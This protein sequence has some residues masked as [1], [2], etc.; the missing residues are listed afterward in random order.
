MNH[1][2]TISILEILVILAGTAIGVAWAVWLAQSELKEVQEREANPYAP[3][4]EG[5]RVGAA[6]IFAGFTLLAGAGMLLVMFA[7]SRLPEQP[8]AARF[9]PWI[10]VAVMV[11]AVALALVDALSTHKNLDA[12]DRDPNSTPSSSF[13]PPLAEV[14]A[15]VIA[16][17][18]PYFTLAIHAA[19]VPVF[20]ISEI[21]AVVVAVQTAKHMEDIMRRRQ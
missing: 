19:I 8:A 4:S 7:A 20:I 18:V 2:P 10:F 5:M 14:F 9:A 12:R 13:S 1:H 6:D 11:V 15:A 21:I 3:H 17:A 16:L